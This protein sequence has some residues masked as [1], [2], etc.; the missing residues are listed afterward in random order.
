VLG[1]AGTLSMAPG[2][3]HPLRQAFTISIRNMKQKMSGP[4]TT[5]LRASGF[6]CCHP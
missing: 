2:S 3:I 5:S 1:P 6:T 4:K